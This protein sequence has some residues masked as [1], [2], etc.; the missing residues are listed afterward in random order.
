MTPY[1]PALRWLIK[2]T[3]RQSLAGY[4]F[5]LMLGISGL[6]ILFCLSIGI[7]QKSPLME[8]GDIEISTQLG[9]V[10]LGFG[11]FRAPL[12]R[13]GSQAVHFLQVL[14]GKWLA[15]TVGILLSLI[16][17]AGFVPA[18]LEPSNASVLLAKPTPR[19]I[20]LLGKYL[21]VLTFVAF[22][23][24]VFV[25]GTWIALGL[26]TDAWHGGYLLCFPIMLLHFVAIF[27]IS[28]LIAVCTRSTVACVFGSILFWLLSYAANFGRHAFHSWSAS[29]PSGTSGT[30]VP[31]LVE[32]GYWF[33]PK[34]ADFGILL[35][36][37]LRAKDHFIS[38]AEFDK[39]QELGLF[40]PALSVLSGVAFAVLTF[41]IAA[42]QFR[43]TNY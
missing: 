10:T 4:S 24:G 38:A 41:V 39:V 7:E 29:G 21:G 12:F 30:P 35:D 1:V 37:A 15:G 26:K 40:H 18:F 9:E 5:W 33:L 28:V 23:F 36:R 20:M 2:D 19:W 43:K 32:A 6:S 17:T 3:F 13:D 34:P 11:A 31:W 25:L 42:R 8:E 27:S 22:Q 14:M 16:W